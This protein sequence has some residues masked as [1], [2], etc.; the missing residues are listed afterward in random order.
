M[1]IGAR[2]GENLSARRKRLDLSQEEVGFRAGLHRTAVGQLERG[3]RVPR[4][5]TV[6]RLAAV[7][8]VPPGDLLVGVEWEPIAYTAG[9]YRVQ[10]A[11]AASDG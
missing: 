8:G 6:I 3:E 2:I 10:P 1:D 9:G 5:D 11:A 7:L 4:A